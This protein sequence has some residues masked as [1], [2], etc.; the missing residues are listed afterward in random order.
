MVNAIA[1]LQKRY[2][3]TKGFLGQDHAEANAGDKTHYGDE[4]QGLH[5]THGHWHFCDGA[6]GI[7]RTGN[8]LKWDF[9]EFNLLLETILGGNA[10]QNLPNDV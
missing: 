1:H 9:G 5:K 10:K 3:H 4:G 7:T 2:G 6:S 8:G